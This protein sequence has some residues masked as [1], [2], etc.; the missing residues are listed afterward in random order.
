MT[1]LLALAIAA[2][3]GPLIVAGGGSTTPAVVRAA[4]DAGGGD[5]AAVLIVP[6][7]SD[8][9]NAGQSSADFWREHGAKSVEILD[10]TDPTKAAA[11][12]ERASLIWMPGGDQNR[13][14]KSL[15]DAKLTDAIRSRHR[16]GAAVGGTSA[17]AAVMSAVMLTGESDLDRIRGGTTATAEGL[18]LWPGVI[19]D[20]HFV[21]RGRF[22][23]LLSA[24]LDRPAMLGV[25]VDE[26]TAAVVAGDTLTVVGGS[27]VVVIDARSAKD[28]AAKAGAPAAATGVTVHVLT[29]GMT[30]RLP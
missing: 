30:F 7:A 20:Q 3:P 13:L 29:A 1:A 14:M 6:Q 17:G 24:V 11:A 5:K 16:A 19:V 18:G 21:R 15:I 22:N 2:H 10:P 26:G 8:R 9:A 28:V 27:Q 12:I 4:L 25:G 23:R